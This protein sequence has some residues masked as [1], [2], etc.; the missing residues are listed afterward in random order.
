MKQE[1]GIVLEL[2]GEL[3]HIRVGRHEECVSCGACGGARN[4]TVD[5]VNGLGAQPGQHVKFE[6]QETNVLTGAFMVFI[7]PLL[8]AALGGFLGWQ[9]GISQGMDVLEQESLRNP[10]VAGAGLFFLLSLIIVKLYDR[11][12][13]RR[14]QSRPVIVEIL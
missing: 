12:A 8:A 5:A 7:L 14:R 3:A 6:M 11:R 4:V 13:G 2:R 10:M 9:L 1:E